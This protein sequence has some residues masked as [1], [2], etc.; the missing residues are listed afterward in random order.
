MIDLDLDAERTVL[1]CAL[2]D[3]GSV[4]RILPRLDA[5]DFGLDSHRRIYHAIT[6]LA[7]AGKP[8]DELTLVDALTAK[9]HLESIGGVAYITAL[10]QKLEGGL[11]RLTN[12]EHYTDMVLDK[13]RRRRVA[14]AA[15]AAL[16][17]AADPATT[18]DDVVAGLEDSLLRVEATVGKALPRSHREILPDLLHELEFQSYNEGLIGLETGLHSLD[19]TTG[20]IRKGELWTIGA[21]PG[22]GKSALAIQIA[23]ANGTKKIPT[24]FF[25]LEMSELEIEKRFLAATSQFAARQLRNPQA[26]KPRLRE[27]GEA[28]AAMSE[29]AIYIDSR[30]SLTIQQLLAS[31]RLYI[32]RHGVKLVIVDYVRLVNAPAVRDLRERVGYVADALRQLAK[33]EQVAVCMLSQLR[34]P[35]GGINTKPSMIDLKET[36]DLECHSHVVLLPHLPTAENGTPMPEEQVLIIGK[37]RAGG[38]GELPVYFDTKRLQFFERTTTTNDS[39]N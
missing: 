39:N 21:L 12:V 9:Q 14:T 13:S 28:I 2:S 29:Y 25:S 5:A 3:E 16:S 35:A 18:T 4:Y 34:R 22:R 27:V 17:A 1:G 6:E 11:A 30:A 31:A 15:Q 7:Q 23:L 38:I 8:V 37:N 24:L 20:G 32:R 19:V 33:S 26:L 36:G 10:S